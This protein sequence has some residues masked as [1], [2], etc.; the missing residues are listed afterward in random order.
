SLLQL[1]Q[2]GLA[3]PFNTGALARYT[4]HLYGGMFGFRPTRRRKRRRT[5]DARTPVS[6]EVRLPLL[7]WIA[8]H[9]IV[10]RLARVRAFEQHPVNGM[11][12]RHVDAVPQGQA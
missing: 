7:F 6:P 2:L 8:P 5:S 11:H 1:V 3:V 12:D 9:Q 4:V 10:H